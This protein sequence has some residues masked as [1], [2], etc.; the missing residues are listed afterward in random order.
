MSISTLFFGCLVAAPV[1]SEDGSA[2]LG[3][4]ELESDVASFIGELLA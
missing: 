1:F 2:A 3:G 4:K